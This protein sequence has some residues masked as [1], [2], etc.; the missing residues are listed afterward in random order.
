VEIMN[1]NNLW[2]TEA[3]SNPD[4]AS[5]EADAGLVGH[6]LRINE[7]ERDVSALEF[8]KRRPHLPH[9]TATYTLNQSEPTTEDLAVYKT[10][11]WATCRIEELTPKFRSR[12]FIRWLG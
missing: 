9:G 6:E 12:Y 11:Y 5:E 3:L 7:L 10:R 4:F 2:I 8:V 1:P